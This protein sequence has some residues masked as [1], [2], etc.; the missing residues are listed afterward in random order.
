MSAIV[1]EGRPCALMRV[2][3]DTFPE[4]AWKVGKVKP[5]V[6]RCGRH[7]AVVRSELAASPFKKNRIAIAVEHVHRGAYVCKRARQRIHRRD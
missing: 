3:M 2:L 5:H 4:G 6:P 1:S 7:Y